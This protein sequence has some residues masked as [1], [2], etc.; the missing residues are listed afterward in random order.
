VGNNNAALSTVGDDMESLDGSVKGSSAGAKFDNA[1][2][3]NLEKIEL[4]LYTSKH[5]K[6]L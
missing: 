5:K 6:R 3:K 2:R 4:N 1:H